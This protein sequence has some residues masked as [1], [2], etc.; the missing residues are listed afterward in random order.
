MNKLYTF[1]AVVG[2]AA[3]GGAAWW[4]QHKAPA[5]GANSAD[6][7]GA[8]ARPGS[9]A[10]GGAVG[11]GG[12]GGPGG[13]GPG[14]G[15][16]PGGPAVVEVAKVERM[17]LSDEAQAVGSLRSRQGVMLRPEVSGRIVALGF[18]DGQRVR[19]GQLLVQMDD[20]LQAAQLKAAQAQA[21]IAQT[22]LQRQRE[23]LAQNF[24]S[25]SAVDQSAANLDV[26]NAQVA[27]AQA[28]SQRLRI[29]A[30]F[31]AMA[32]I[33]KVDVG[34]YVKDGADIVALEDSGAL[35]V[36]FRLP[37]R[38]LARLKPGQSTEVTLDALPGRKFQAQVEAMDALVDANGRSLL[39]KARLG[40]AQGE[41]KPGMFARTRTVFATRDDALVVPEEA[42]VPQGGRQ[43]IVK[44]IEGKDGAK[45]GQRIEAKLG[46]RRPGKVEVLEG[47]N[48]GD[49]VVT[50]GQGRLMRPGEP[51]P[52]RIVD[53]SRP[54]G[55]AGAPGA[56][57]SGGSAPAG[58][59][60]AAA[61]PANAGAAAAGAAGNAP[62]AATS[63]P[64]P[65]KP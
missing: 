51:Q 65:P 49:L 17:S 21:A 63:A 61:T 37:E 45:L 3:A 52:L 60:G 1:V 30:P 59:P 29:L 48:E 31:D 36:D 41:L 22:N 7:A 25:Q 11:P 18:K 42:L 34:D 4:Y 57:G 35:Y 16:G 33:R 24:V 43:F 26:A 64:Q 6:A 55:S 9:G 32:G 50:A 56:P 8:A 19:K 14:G 39:V 40:N 2:I 23:L 27:L 10:A 5:A 62:S 58:T 12:P 20:T 15:R 54:P 13:A 47:L 28:Q 38:V 44:V 46:L 53:L